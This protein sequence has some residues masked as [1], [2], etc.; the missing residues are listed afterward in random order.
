[1]SPKKSKATMNPVASGL[2]DIG[3]RRSNNEDSFCILDKKKPT[4][5]L[6]AIADGMG[7][8][9][10]GEVASELT[11]KAIKSFFKRIDT[12]TISSDIIIDLINKINEYVFYKAST[13]PQLSGM[14]NTLSLLL[15]LNNNKIVIGHVGDSRIYRLREKKFE[16]LTIDHTEVQAMIDAGQLSK[17]AARHHPLRNLIRQA[18]GASKGL[19]N[20]FTLEEEALIN[21]KYL[22]C[23]DGLTDMLEDE[24]IEEILDCSATPDEAV[25]AL[26]HAALEAGG[27]DNVTA[28]V[29]RIDQ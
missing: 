11:V 7:G 27:R 29:V 16:Q 10:A 14:G 6:Y 23:S 22:L 8:H 17:E 25:N 4:T 26:I 12:D 28:I 19:D 2:T 3:K 21:D 13:N 15:I 24:K 5:F 18:I 9:A 1:M 20:I